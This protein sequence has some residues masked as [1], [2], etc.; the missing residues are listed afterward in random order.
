MNL[1]KSLNR[2]IYTGIFVMLLFSSCVHLY[3]NTFDVIG[4]VHGIRDSVVY[5]TLRSSRD[6]LIRTDTIMVREGGVFE[7]TGKVRDSLRVTLTIPSH[8]GNTH[9]NL[10]FTLFNTNYLIHG[11][12]DSISSARI[13]SGSDEE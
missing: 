7:Y 12:A 10:S 5:F 1:P 6:S 2:N 9:G 4:S 3:K 13:H 8:Q 11:D